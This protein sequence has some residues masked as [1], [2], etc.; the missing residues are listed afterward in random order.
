MLLMTFNGTISK[1]YLKTTSHVPVISLKTISRHVEIGYK[2]MFHQI[3]AKEMVCI[4][5]FI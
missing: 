1:L 3:G 4:S 2:N 5:G